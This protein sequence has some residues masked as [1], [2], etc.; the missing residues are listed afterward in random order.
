MDSGRRDLD[1]LSVGTWIL[2]IVVGMLPVAGLVGAIV[3]AA[4]R[5]P[6]KKNIGKAY[7]ILYAVAAVLCIGLWVIFILLISRPHDGL[8]IS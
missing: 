7:L 4:G 1:V 5:D 8:P 3:L 2:Y 6:T